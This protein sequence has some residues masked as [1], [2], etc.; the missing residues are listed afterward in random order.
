MKINEIKRTIEEVVR[1][2]Y[3]A[4]DGT[5]FD[6]R[7]E[8]LKYERSALGVIKAKLKPMT[9]FNKYSQ[10]DFID[11]GSDECLVEIFAIESQEDLDNIN[12]YLQ[13]VSCH[14]PRPTQ[15]PKEAIGHEAILFWNYDKDYAYTYEDGT[16]EGFMTYIRKNFE[17]MTKPKEETK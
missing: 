4:N 5:V 6:D 14:Y 17:R 10:Y 2:E 15:I 9:N 11:M 16:L 8:C 12:R 13:A 1:T 7:D 3:I